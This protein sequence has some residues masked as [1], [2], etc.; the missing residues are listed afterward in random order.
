MAGWISGVTVPIVNIAPVKKFG[1][2]ELIVCAAL[3]RRD[4]Q[5]DYTAIRKMEPPSCVRGQNPSSWAKK[6]DARRETLFGK[7]IEIVA[8]DDVYA[9]PTKPN[10]EGPHAMAE[11]D[12]STG[13]E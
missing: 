5:W 1:D 12:P 2:E 10:G 4:A 6:R 11:A 13:N 7:A 8:T 3:R 9:K